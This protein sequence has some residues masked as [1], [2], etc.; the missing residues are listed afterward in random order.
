MDN[1][2]IFHF[3]APDKKKEKK[4]DRQEIVEGKIAIQRE[5]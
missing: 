5:H 3:T 4:D 1:A 2:F